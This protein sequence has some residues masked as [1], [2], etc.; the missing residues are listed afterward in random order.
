MINN[1]LERTVHRGG[2]RH[3]LFAIIVAVGILTG[4]GWATTTTSVDPRDTKIDLPLRPEL[5]V[6]SQACAKC[7]AAEVNVWKQTPHH[8]TFL[9]LHRKPQ[10]Q[11]IADKL[12][13][14]S[15]KHDS[16]CIKCHYS[17]QEQ[18]GGL[19]PIAG[20]SCES[21][22]GAAKSWID[23]HHDYGGPG[24]KR[25]QESAEHR[26]QRLVTSITAGMRNPENVYLVAQSCYRCHT[27]PDEK[28]VN[29]GGHVAGSL[30]FEL[31][32]WSQGKVRHNFVRTDGKQNEPSS[33]ERM[34]LMFVSGMI[35][36]LE[37]SL[38]ATAEATVKETYGVTSASR[39]ARAAKRLAAAQ[40]KLSQPVL[41]E[42]LNAFK[43]VQLKLN[44]RDQLL[45]AADKVA[46]MGLRFAAT[47]RGA[48]L[49][50]MDAF[51]P[52]PDQWK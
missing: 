19:E 28:L 44:N 48:D 10:A 18:P 27:V 41:D 45:A 52:K 8:E 21:C 51:M 49:A 29:V 25:D 6:G 2:K 4:I 50:A 47:V 26:Y 12:G 35:A 16:A 13:I 43:S 38:R 40:E 3:R 32:A 14:S 7:H 17:M 9:T 22:H 23:H 24:V 15:F 31:V 20:V 37:F 5:V 34:R 30:N 42:V 39:A 36:D 33:T 11:Q 46:E 1:V